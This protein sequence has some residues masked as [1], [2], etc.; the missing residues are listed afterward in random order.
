MGASPITT[1]LR[2]PAL[3]RFC[4][5]RRTEGI[6][7]CWRTGDH[8]WVSSDYAEEII[9]IL[10]RRIQHCSSM[11]IELWRIVR[12]QTEHLLTR[13]FFW[14]VGHGVQDID[15][16]LT[17][18]VGKHHCQGR[19]EGV[20]PIPVSLWRPRAGWI[21]RVGRGTAPWTDFAGSNGWNRCCQW[22]HRLQTW[23]SSRK[24]PLPPDLEQAA[25]KYRWPAVF[26]ESGRHADPAVKGREQQIHD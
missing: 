21:P 3:Y 13:S 20:P 10:Y 25:G 12:S 24:R 19:V 11:T 2:T 23:R 22:I 18:N 14:L 8:H 6:I 16:L 7:F 5:R 9:L 4:G 26:A 15:H 17:R 1:T